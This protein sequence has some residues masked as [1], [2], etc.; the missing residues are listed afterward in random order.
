[1]ICTI[2]KRC[3]KSVCWQHAW[4]WAGRRLVDNK[5]GEQVERLGMER[6]SRVLPPLFATLLLMAVRPVVEQW[7]PGHLL[8]LAI[9]L[10]GSFAAI[11]FMFYMLRQVFARHSKASGGLLGFERG[12][13]TLV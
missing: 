13:A 6:F 7:Y 4:S 9:P 11:R 3:G 2:G 5:E 12:L 8:R 10:L 1:M